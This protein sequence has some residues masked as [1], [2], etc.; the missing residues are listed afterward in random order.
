LSSLPRLSILIA[1]SLP[2]IFRHLLAEDSETG[3][4]FTQAQL[5]SNA[6]LI[7]VAG[8]DT[9]SSTLSQTFG[10]LAKDQRILKK[11]QEE[12]DSVREK[13]EELTVETTKN[14]VYLNGVVNEALRLLNP[15]PSGVQATTP[16]IGVEVADVHLPGSIQVQVPHI[17]LMTDERY[18][19]NPEEFIPERWTGEKPQL[20]LEKRA[21]IPFGYG[22]HSCVGKQL[23]LNEMRLVLA[24]VVRKFDV[25]RGE[26][27]DEERFR[28]EWMDYAVL[29]IGAMWVK[30]VLRG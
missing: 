5:N 26:S 21:F 23:A 20:L 1:R 30:F 12:I 28:E 24:R 22:V 13:G 14:L 9:T 7:I 2:D 17:V 18:F 15:I 4:K 11:L 29:H 8:S 27:Y 25:V 6:N 3:S 19:P 16:T 10:V